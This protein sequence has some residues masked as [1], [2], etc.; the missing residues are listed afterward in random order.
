MW[1]D[2][3]IGLQCTIVTWL[4]CICA[5]SH[6]SDLLSSPPLSLSLSFSLSAPLRIL[7]GR[8]YST[9]AIQLE[10]MAVRPSERRRRQAS[11]K[12]KG[13]IEI[14]TAISKARKETYLHMELARGKKDTLNRLQ[15]PTYTK[16][17]L[18]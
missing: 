2:I 16:C 4:P 12:G 9:T 3:N 13:H 11:K 10:F 1:M 6:R 17:E 5:A 18:P 7:I 14:T 8:S 15:F